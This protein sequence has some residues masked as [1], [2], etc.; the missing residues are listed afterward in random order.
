MIY[1]VTYDLIVSNPPFFSNS[2]KSSD[3]KRNIARHTDFLSSAWLLKGVSRLLSVGGRFVV[4]LPYQQSRTFMLE[5]LSME[6]YCNRI[7]YI[8][9]S[10]QK[11]FNRVIM[12]MTRNRHKSEETELTIRNEDRNFSEAYRLLTRDYYLAF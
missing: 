10:P 9:P 2:L 6:I 8:K 4:I 12:E 3:E 5:A 1:G 11:N 7:L